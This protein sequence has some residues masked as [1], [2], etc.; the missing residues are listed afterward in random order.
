MRLP[1]CRERH[2]QARLIRNSDFHG[3]CIGGQQRSGAVALPL[4]RVRQLELHAV[5]DVGPVLLGGE[6]G[7][8]PARRGHLEGVS[9]RDR[10]RDVERATGML[11]DQRAIVDRDAVLA[12]DVDAQQRMATVDVQF[13][14]PEFV[15]ERL[16]NRRQQFTQLFDPCRHAV[17]TLLQ[18]QKMGTGPT[19]IAPTARQFPTASSR[20][21]IATASAN[22]LTKSPTR[23]LSGSLDPQRK[24]TLSVAT[25]AL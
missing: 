4:D 7:A 10:V 25:P 18:K 21:E 6:Q 13:H 14:A 5:A 23:G 11:A 8:V 15:A 19:S 16:D 3:R 9:T 2:S 17:I 20:Q 1:D 24:M 22:H 12:V